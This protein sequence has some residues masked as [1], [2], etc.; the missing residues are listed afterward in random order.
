MVSPLLTDSYMV[1]A[2]DRKVVF[3]SKAEAPRWPVFLEVI[4][5]LVIL[6]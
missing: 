1:K 6:L 3:L 2:D 5:H 4:F